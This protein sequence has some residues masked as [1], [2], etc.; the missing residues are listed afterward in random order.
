MTTTQLEAAAR[1]LTVV[2]P[3]RRDSVYWALHCTLLDSREQQVA[4]DQV[5]ASFWEGS[6]PTVPLEIPGETQSGP[7]PTPEPSP[8]DDPDGHS[9]LSGDANSSREEADGGDDGEDP[10]D[11]GRLEAGLVFSAEERLR[12][13]DFEAYSEAEMLE[14]ERLIGR[15]GRSV[16]MRQARRLRAAQSGAR[17]DLRQTMRRAMRTEGHPLDLA[18]RRRGL[19]PRPLVFLIDVSGS[20]ESYAGPMFAFAWGARRSSKR[21]EAFAF[22]TRLTRLTGALERSRYREALAAVADTV[23]D[24][25]GGTRIGAGLNAFSRRWGR[26][27]MCRGAAVVIVS[28]GWE[29]GDV[30]ELERAMGTIKRLAHTVFWV[31]PL[32]ADRDYE[33]LAAGMAAAMPFID[34][35][36]P[37][38]SIEDLRVLA[39][40]LAA[41]PIRRHRRGPATV[42]APTR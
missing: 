13:L 8:S 6:T 1:A 27:G 16:P 23:P 29:R 35:F 15:L 33:P 9:G 4:F 31:N 26:R 37:G 30:A 11:E 24:W 5:F 17:L 32:A 42:P 21:V 22:G 3:S 2:D 20:M 10:D 12:H 25:A 40:R 7:S 36:L 28:D 19:R 41:L 34:H 18:W 39:D 38:H 14:A